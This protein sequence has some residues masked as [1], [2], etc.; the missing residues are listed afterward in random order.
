MAEAKNKPVRKYR[1]G[2][3][4]GTVWRNKLTFK[5]KDGKEVER[6]VESIAFTKIYKD[7]DDNWQ[8]TNSYNRNEVPKLL[9]LINRYLNDQII[10]GDSSEPKIEEIPIA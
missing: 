4:T 5:G 3:V 2:N 8:N 7:K 10:E 1:L 6:E 9:A